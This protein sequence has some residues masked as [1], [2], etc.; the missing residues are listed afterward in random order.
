MQQ[1]LPSAP[2]AKSVWP[3]L[4]EA[5]ASCCMPS[6]AEHNS[7]LEEPQVVDPAQHLQFAVVANMQPHQQALTCSNMAATTSWPLLLLE[8]G[9]ITTCCLLLLQCVL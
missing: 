1:M 8:I 6:A 9:M 2:A 3:V 5:Q 7:Q 4:V